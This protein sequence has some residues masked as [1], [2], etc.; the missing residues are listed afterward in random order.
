VPPRA[1]IRQYEIKDREERR[2]AEERRR[3]LEKAKMKK[4]RGKKGKGNKN[5]AQNPP[6]DNNQAY[7]PT[8]DNVPLP[9]DA[10]G[11]GEEYYD[12]DYDDGYDSVNGVDPGEPGVPDGFHDYGPDTFHGQPGPPPA[13]PAA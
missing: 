13:A 8:L 7:D 11:Q 6:R 4:G 5:A 2:K 12:D 10:D 9:P 1:L 3:L